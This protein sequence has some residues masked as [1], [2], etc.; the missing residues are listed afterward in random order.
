MTDEN[1]DEIGPIDYLVVEF[2]AG[3]QN[4]NG[5]V[6]AELAALV[7]AGI[8]N[9]LDLMIITKNDAGEVEAFEID[10]LDQ[11][12]ELRELEREIAEILA[13][14]DVALLAEAME[15]GSVAGVIVWENRWSA[16]FASAVRR[17]GGQLIAN[18][19]I[20]IQALVASIEADD[21]LTEG[22]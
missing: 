4:F 8:I 10:D 13:A 9:L 21:D 16:P 2:P 17:A 19:R 20:P 6:A 12:D 22:E 15:K 7:E 5:E 3:H 14:D 1:I 18:G 11:I